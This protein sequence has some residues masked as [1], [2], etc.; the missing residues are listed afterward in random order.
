MIREGKKL[1]QL[2]VAEPKSPSKSN[3][4]PKG[5]KSSK[6]SE[7]SND[8]PWEANADDTKEYKK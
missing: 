5:T 7:P 1:K 2:Q 6:Q 3:S 8:E 4:E